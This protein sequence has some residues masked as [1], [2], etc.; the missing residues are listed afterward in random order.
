[1]C[2]LD[3]GFTS[4]GIRSQ[5][6]FTVGQVALKVASSKVV[7]HEK[8]CSNNQHAFIPFTFHNFGFLTPEVVDV[9]VYNP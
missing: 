5:V 1:M 4:R 2:G 7:K 6:F 8:A 9:L 3:L